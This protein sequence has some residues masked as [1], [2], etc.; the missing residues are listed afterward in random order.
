M[1][2]HGHDYFSTIAGFH[3]FHGFMKMVEGESMSDYGFEVE[4]ACLEYAT[5]AIPGIEDATAR[6]AEDGRAFEDDVVRQ[7]KFDRARGY[8]KE[9]DP[10]AVAQYLEALAYGLR[11]ARHF[12]DDIDTEAIGDI[13][14][15]PHR[16]DFTRVEDIVCAHGRGD[17]EALVVGFDGKDGTGARDATE[18][19]SPETDGTATEDGNGFV[20]DFASEG[21]MYGIAKGFLN[22]GNGMFDFFASL[23]GDVFRDGD[24]FRERAVA[25]DTEYLYVTANVGLA[26]TALVA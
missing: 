1:P 26:G 22:R 3:D 5:G 9:R 8:P 12:Q 15:L 6:D 7:V 13:E 24:V 14:Y 18:A 20:G 16:I 10:A 2:L 19:Y 4:L 23:P 25:I 17:V 21:G 11:V